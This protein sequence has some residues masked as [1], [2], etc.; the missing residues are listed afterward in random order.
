MPPVSFTD[1][2]ADVDRRRAAGDVE[3]AVALLRENVKTFPLHRG[4][5]HLVL[6]EILVAAGRPKEAVDSLQEAFTAGCRYKADWLTGDAQLAPLVADPRFIKVVRKVDERY[7]ADAAA[8]RPDLLI[9]APAGAP[10]PAGRPLLVAL[11]GNNSNARETARYWSSAVNDGWVVAI[12]QSS[13]VGM[14]PNAFT[15]NDRARAHAETLVHVARAKELHRIDERRIVLAG[16]SMGGLQAIALPLALGFKARGIIPVA[17]WL[18]H[19]RELAPLVG[20][21]AARGLRA[22]VVV[23]GDD[24]SHAGAKHLV[25]LLNKDGAT[26]RLDARPGLG[27]EYPAD[28]DAT[29]TR[30]LEFVAA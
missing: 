14:S 23:G 4:V 18:P 2:N 13:E 5:V 10:A 9:R 30:A 16:F 15:W 24:P 29:L 26:A 1:L 3:G 27:H 17:A 28:M 11:H 22:Y 8:A 19:V 6:A 21:G 25:D 12:P 20:Q 7:V